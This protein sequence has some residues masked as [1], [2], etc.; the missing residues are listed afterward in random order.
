MQPLVDA[1]V[2][3]YEVGFAAE[4]GWQQPGFPSFDYAAELLDNR[5]AN[6]CAMVEATQPPILYLT[7]KTNFRTEIAKLRQYKERPSLKPFH[8]YNL[9]AY[10]K[11][12]YDWR[13]TEGLEADD[14]MAI[15]QCK[16]RGNPLYR[17]VETIICTRDKDLRAVPGWH[18][19]WELGMQPQYGPTFVTDL[20]ALRLSSNRKSLK[21]E[22]LLFFYS[23]C[24]TGDSV[25]TVP[26]LPKW[27][28]V[29][30]YE[31]LAECPT[32]SSAFHCVLEAYRGLYG[33]LAEEALLEQGR[34]LWMTRELDEEGKPVLWQLP[35]L[36]MENDGQKL[37]IEPLL[38]ADLEVLV[39]DGLPDM[40]ALTQQKL[41]SESI[42]KQEDSQ[43]TTSAIV[44]N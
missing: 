33:A 26:G 3:L 1:D 36:E 2:L 10:I 21:G 11:G 44:A 29:K 15:E 8:Y 20:G 40:S 37:N 14:L 4:A 12:K 32:I 6:I 5:I 19:G 7:G 39:S 34:L 28:P 35:K 9:K 22:G 38:K 27:G 13:L 24:L 17:G 16:H 30:A 18:Y 23:Q 31:L 43:S 41:E 42:L 25:D